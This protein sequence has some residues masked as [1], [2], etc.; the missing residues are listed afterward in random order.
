M[1][2]R[3]ASGSVTPASAVEEALAGRRRRRGRRRSP[4]RS[5]SRP[6]RPRPRAAARGRRRR[7]SAG[8]RPPAARARPRRTSRRRRTARRAPGRRRPARGPRST[9]SSTTLAGGPV[10]LDA[11]AAPEE[12]LDDPLP[13][14]G[15]HDLRVPLHAVEPPLVVLER[16]DRRAGRRGGHPETVRRRASPSRR[17]TSTPTARRAGR[18]TASSRC[19]TPTRR[20]LPYSRGPVC[21]DRAAERL[22]HRLEP[23]A[24]AEDRDAR[25]EQCRVEARRARPRRRELGPPDRMIAAGLLREQVARPA[26]CAARPR[27]RPAPRGRAAR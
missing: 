22:G 23:V 4:R 15:V 20:C 1:I 19:A 25:L 27:C 8:R 10:R 2:L 11:G 14:L 5:P 26:W 9:S 21:G 3:F 18:R 6:A 17:A 16:G 13:E 12:V 24:H 7:R